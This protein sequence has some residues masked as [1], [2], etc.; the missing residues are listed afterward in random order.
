MGWQDSERRAP[1][2]RVQRPPPDSGDV[3]AAAK[4]WSRWHP[5]VIYGIVWVGYK[6]L[7]D[8]LDLTPAAV[9]IGQATIISRAAVL[10]GI[11]AVGVAS[12]AGFGLVA[13]RLALPSGSVAC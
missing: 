13:Y 11:L 2:H 12:C 7:Y 1:S 5:A 10:I 8:G 4:R 3:L 6:E 9:G